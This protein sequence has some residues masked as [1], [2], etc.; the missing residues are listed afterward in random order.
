MG[1]L[2]GLVSPKSSTVSER[3][4]QTL[5]HLLHEKSSYH[6]KCSSIMLKSVQLS[7]T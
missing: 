4:T 2:G 7:L 1:L 3:E 6:P 5:P